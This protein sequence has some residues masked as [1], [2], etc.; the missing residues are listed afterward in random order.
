MGITFTNKEIN[1]I[2]K[3]IDKGTKQSD[4]LI[5]PLSEEDAETRRKLYNV[6]DLLEEGKVFL[7]EPQCPKCGGKELE[8]GAGILLNSNQHCPYCKT[9]FTLQLRHDIRKYVCEIHPEGACI[10]DIAYLTP[11]QNPYNMGNI[12]IGAGTCAGCGKTR[13]SGSILNGVPCECGYVPADIRKSSFAKPETE[14]VT[15]NEGRQKEERARM[16]GCGEVHKP[17]ERCG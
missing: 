2:Y 4:I 9:N 11:K 16:C 17:S 6:L 7:D 15:C 12:T 8:S 14:K 1:I 5:V 10:P 3:W 13:G